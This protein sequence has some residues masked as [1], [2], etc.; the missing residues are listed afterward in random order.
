[1]IGATNRPQDVDMAFLRPGRFDELIGIGLPDLEARKAIFKVHTKD[2]PLTDDIDLDMLA[3][4]TEMF[5]GAEIAFI[6]DT[7]RKAVA[8]EALKSGFRKIKMEDF[9]QQSRVIV[10]G[11][12]GLLS[13]CGNCEKKIYIGPRFFKHRWS[14]QAS[15]NRVG[16]SSNLQNECYTARL[17]GLA[18]EAQERGVVNPIH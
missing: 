9:V 8:K 14:G 13:L 17:C 10:V 18:M 11:H 1:M 5:T 16:L 2:M 15:Y 12:A 3:E 6:C 4:K 7:A